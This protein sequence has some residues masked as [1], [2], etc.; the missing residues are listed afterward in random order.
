VAPE[1]QQLNPIYFS[2]QGQGYGPGMQAYG[3]G[4]NG[5]FGG[6]GGAGGNGGNGG[7]GQDPYGYYGQPGGH[8]N[9]PKKHHG[10]FWGLGVGALAL[11]IVGG[12]F[13]G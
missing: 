11:A 3:Q 8:H 6:A 1:Q 10:L 4:G 9:Q 12:G 7:W 13:G 5:G 2:Q